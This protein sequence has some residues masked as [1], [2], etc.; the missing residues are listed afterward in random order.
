MTRFLYH[1]GVP[2]LRRGDV[3]TPRATGDTA[4]LVDGCPT[5]EARRAGVPLAGDDLDPSMVYVTTDREYAR[6]YAA[7][8]PRGALYRVD[9]D[10]DLDVRSPDP[11][12]SWAVPSARVVAVLDALVILSPSDLRRMVRRYAIGATA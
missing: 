11:V 12:P 6:L 5:C 8:Y 10:G 4:H 9:V 2:G 7:G 3:I 1:G